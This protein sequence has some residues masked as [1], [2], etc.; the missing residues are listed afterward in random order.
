MDFNTALQNWL[1]AVDVEV[2]EPLQNAEWKAKHGQT[3]Q[4]LEVDDG[5]KFLRIVSVTLGNNRS[6]WAFVAKDDG[7]NKQLGNWKK[8]DIFKSASWKGPAK[9]AR[10]NIFDL[11]NGATCGIKSPY[12][13]DYLK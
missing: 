5:Q 2:I 8:G 13:P 7:N 9:H 11:T 4:T 3:Y 12:G 10:G 1:K 6:S